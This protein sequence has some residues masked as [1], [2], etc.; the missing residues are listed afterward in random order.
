MFT[1]ALP[2]GSQLPARIT[3]HS[4]RAGWVSD[5]T[6]RQVPVHTIM[7]QGRWSSTKAFRDY[8]RPCIRDLSTSN[9]FRLIPDEVREQWP[10]QE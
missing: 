2:V 1:L 10:P 7:A 3:P 9:R 6:R 4:M 5:Q 8:I